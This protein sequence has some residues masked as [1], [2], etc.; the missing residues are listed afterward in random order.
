MRLKT[1]YIIL[2]L[3]SVNPLVAQMNKNQVVKNINTWYENNPNV[4]ELSIDKDDAVV[5][6]TR[7]HPKI[8]H[9]KNNLIRISYKGMKITLAFSKPLNVITTDK[10]SLQKYCSYLVIDHIYHDINSKG[11]TLY[12]RTPSSSLRGKGINFIKG[13]DSLSFTINW[14]INTV[15]GYKDSKAC[16]EERAM[17]DSSVSEPCYVGVNKKLKLKINVID[18]PF[19][20]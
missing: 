16:N 15:L 4:Y 7:Y 5:N 12:P 20:K 19:S 17:M 13:G 14:S 10:D 9:E 11:W 6:V 1:V 8:E 2:I 3:F 18:V